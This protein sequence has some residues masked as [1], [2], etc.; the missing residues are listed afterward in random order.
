MS[1]NNSGNGSA[2][3]PAD[4]TPFDLTASIVVLIVSVTFGFTLTTLLAVAAMPGITDSSAALSGAVSK[5]IL[6]VGTVA[7]IVPAYFYM[8][9]VKKDLAVTFRF[10]RVS[11]KTIL[12]TILLSLGLVVL[13]DALDKGISPWINNFLDQ[14]IGT[15]SPELRSEKIIARMAQEFKLNN[16]ASG[17]LLILAAV[18]AAGFCE[19]MLL[20][21]MFQGALEK[22]MNAAA[23]IAISSFVFALIH[24]N[25][26]GGVQIFILAIFLGLVA[27][28]TNSI[29]PT[30]I[31]HGLNNLLVIVFNNVDPAS[32]TWY[33][34]EKHIESYVIIIGSLLTAIGLAGI[35]GARAS[36]NS[37]PG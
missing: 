34:D 15:L 31:M 7:F 20:R 19:E 5:F 10:H 13:T 25:P 30:I 17:L 23:A 26:W 24:F 3:I 28:E 29:I 22:K 32:L 9:Y 12:F 6:L 8:R 27:W 2:I 16:L 35:F 36:R 21:G 14:T 4:E 37:I 1:E 18:A 33:G 11:S